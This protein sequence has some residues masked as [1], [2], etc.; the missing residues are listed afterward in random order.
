[1]PCLTACEWGL[2]AEGA[3]M[4]VQATLMLPNTNTG[5]ADLEF[6]GSFEPSKDGLD[7]VALFD[8]TCWRLE[9]IDAALNLR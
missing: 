9:L 1:M 4:H 6:R 7:A 2:D 8:G 5:M 3:C